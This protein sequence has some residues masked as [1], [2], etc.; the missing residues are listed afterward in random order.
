[1]HLNSKLQARQRPPQQLP[2]GF[3]LIELMVGLV[4]GMIAVIV[5]MQVFSLSSRGQRTATGGDDA[6]MSGALA[7]AQLQRD[8]RQSGQGLGYSRLLGCSIQLPGGLLTA[9]GR[10]VINHPNIPAGDPNTDTVVSLNGSSFGS[11][12]GDRV[13]G[14]AVGNVYPV[15]T[16]TAFRQNDFVVA[17]W[18]TR[19]TP[20]N[21][22]L[23][24]VNAVPV[25]NNLSVAVGVAPSPE[26]VY[27]LG[28]A[29]R[30]MA[31]AVRGGRLT[32]CDFMLVDCRVN[33][34]AN[35]PEIGDGVVSLRAQYLYAGNVANQNTPAGANPLANCQAWQTVVGLRFAVTTRSGQLEREAVTVAA[36]EPTWSASAAL[37]INLSGTPNWRNYRYKVFEA[38][39]PLRNNPQCL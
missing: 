15:D 14:L 25:L 19:P 31:Y 37:P 1:M 27:N 17:A 6:Q 12:D 38:V 18:R 9:L 20:C 33:N 23:D 36:N 10:V 28:P 13:S 32:Q 4:L 8:L 34:A 30:A 24:R 35:W 22:L 39:V 5:I 29:P 16:F 3:S 26:V 2:R 7:I 11:P 21:L